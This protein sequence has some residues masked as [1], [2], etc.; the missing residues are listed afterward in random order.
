[1]RV[2][3]LCNDSA[4]GRSAGTRVCDHGGVLEN[5]SGTAVQSS[6]SC[7]SNS[8]FNLNILFSFVV[9]ISEVRC[10]CVFRNSHSKG[11]PP[12]KLQQSSRCRLCRTARTTGSDHNMARSL[13]WRTLGRICRAAA[14]EDAQKPIRPAADRN[15]AADVLSRA[16]V[17]LDGRSTGEISE[18][19]RYLM[20]KVTS[21]S[22]PSRPMDH[23]RRTSI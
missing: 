5:R 16:I 2:R 20:K 8:L 15:I 23:A 6:W 7:G 3:N 17:G 21:Q 19:I 9:V 11:V 10:N 12:A 22:S 14:G 4:A 1:V 13:G 18:S